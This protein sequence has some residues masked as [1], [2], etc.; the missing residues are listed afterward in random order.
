MNELALGVLRQ[1][2]RTSRIQYEPEDSPF[3][4]VFVDLTHRCNMAC[5]NCYIPVRDLPDLPVDWLYPVLKRLPRRTRIRLAGAEPTVRKDLPDIISQVRAH[6]HIPVLL[7]NGLKLGRRAYVRRLKEAGL[8]TMHFSANG[9]LRDDLYETLDGMP[10]AKR[11]LAAL[12]NALAERMNV[13]IGMIL[14]RGVNED[15]LP[16]FLAYVIERGVR[17]IHLRSV[18]AMGRYMPGEPFSLDEQEALVRSALPAG[19]PLQ[20]LRA[21]GSSRDA[22]VGRVAIQMT[23]WPDLG[24]RERGRITPEGKVEPMFESILSNEFRY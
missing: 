22:R 14:A 1:A 6:G 15:H 8:R 7:T 9:G 4:A 11:K 3:T 5:H 21:H 13:T 12:D 19:E 18:G 2:H 23:E 16:E 10:C 24:S 20:I 17:D